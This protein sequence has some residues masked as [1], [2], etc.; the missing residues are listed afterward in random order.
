MASRKPCFRGRR[1]LNSGVRRLMKTLVMLIVAATSGVTSSS[2]SSG[3]S[4]LDAQLI[5][6]PAPPA[7]RVTELTDGEVVIRF[8]VKADGSVAAATVVSSTGHR[9]WVAAAVPAVREWRFTGSA[10]GYTRDVTL[11]FKTGGGT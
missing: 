6:C 9:A 2:G 3:C 5:H 8:V 7:P 10:S 4:L 1:R 11:K